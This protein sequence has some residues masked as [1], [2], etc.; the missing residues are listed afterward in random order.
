LNTTL[1]PHSIIHGDAC[2]A[3]STRSGASRWAIVDNDK[4]ALILSKIPK[5]EE[6]YKRFYNNVLE[7]MQN[8]PADYWCYRNARNATDGFNWMIGAWH[9]LTG[10]PWPE[11]ETRP[12][13]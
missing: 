6:H 10:E 8:V 5:A 9:T 7:Q 3:T 13:R 11:P 1:T 12:L 4:M 2:F